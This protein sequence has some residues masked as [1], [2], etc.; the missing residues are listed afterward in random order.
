[1]LATD[2]CN[3]LADINGMLR[4]RGIAVSRYP[5][6]F[7]AG[8]WSSPEGLRIFM[9]ALPLKSAAKTLALLAAGGPVLYITSRP[10]ESVFVT[11]RWLIINGFPPGKIVFT[12]NKVE[13]AE[14]LN[15]EIMFE[16]DPA[17]ALK[18]A[19]KDIIVGLI[20]Q[21]YNVKVKHEN[22]IHF[23][24]WKSVERKLMSGVES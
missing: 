22:I 1:M 10:P 11:K 14:R 6:K 17:A 9:S 18:L 12:E 20:N 3:T 5:A 7:P 21:P 23:N 8:F 16:D 2:I 24:G 13:A 19:Q 15:V 4:E